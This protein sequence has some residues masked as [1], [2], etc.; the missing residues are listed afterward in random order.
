MQLLLQRLQE[1]KKWIQKDFNQIKNRIFLIFPF[2]IL[3]QNVYDV[4][5]SVLCNILTI[6][7]D[8][9]LH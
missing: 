3:S 7:G 1:K 9:A 8:V 5:F 4:F 2:K 6:D